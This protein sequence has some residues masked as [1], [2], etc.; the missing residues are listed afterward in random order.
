M[1]PAAALTAVWTQP[2]LH[3]GTL[4][5]R[6]PGPGGQPAGAD[7]RDRRRAGAASAP[8]CTT[9]RRRSTSSAARR[10]WFMLSSLSSSSWAALARSPRGCNL[11]IDF[12]GGTAW[13]V[14][15]GEPSSATH[16]MR[17]PPSSTTPRSRSLG[18]DT[19]ARCR[20]SSRTIGDG[21]E[22]T[23]LAEAADVR[24]RVTWTSTRSARR[25]ATRSSKKAQR[26][27]IF[28]FIAIS[29]YITLRFEWKMAV[30]AHR[31]GG[32]RHPR[33]RRRVRARPGSRSR[34]RR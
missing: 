19:A 9:A 12:E 5:R 30:A 16:A 1:H 29:L 17:S 24:A 23:A 6:G 11:G 13:E 2:V 34:R 14:P 15:A 28:F 21:D 25:G 8:G 10:R 33:H 7:E 20:P 22:V 26:A 4:V 27:L 31:R 18:G 32:P 3:R